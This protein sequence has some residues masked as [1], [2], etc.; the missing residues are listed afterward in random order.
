MAEAL[1]FDA[2]ILVEQTPR[3][4]MLPLDEPDA[5]EPAKSAH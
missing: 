2:P 1:G 5:E 4:E 3:E